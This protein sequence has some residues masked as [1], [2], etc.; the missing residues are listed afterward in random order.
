LQARSSKDPDCGK[1]RQSLIEKNSVFLA[2][3]KHEF[4]VELPGLLVATSAAIKRSSQ[5]LKAANM[6][7]SAALIPLL[8]LCLMVPASA[9]SVTDVLNNPA[10]KPFITP[11]RRGCCRR[12]PPRGLGIQIPAWSF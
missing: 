4:K 3:K 11:V 1:R 9:Q 7:R 2:R 8:A 10:L 12:R 6:A 5:R